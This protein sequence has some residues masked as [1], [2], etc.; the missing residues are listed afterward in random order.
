MYST[1][2]TISAFEKNIFFLSGETVPIA[3][4]NMGE[5][6]V[7]FTIIYFVFLKSHQCYQTGN[8]QKGRPQKEQFLNKITLIGKYLRLET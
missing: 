8:I 2:C 5:I 4:I 1:K 7:N 3:I 6:M